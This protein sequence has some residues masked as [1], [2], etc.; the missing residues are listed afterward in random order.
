MG[1][2]LLVGGSVPVRYV[3]ALLKTIR[4][5]QFVQ[6]HGQMK[7]VVLELWE[8]VALKCCSRCGI[9]VIYLASLSVFNKLSFIGA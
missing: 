8:F 4:K 1:E 3:L 7:R 2:G 9:R 5:E 6:L